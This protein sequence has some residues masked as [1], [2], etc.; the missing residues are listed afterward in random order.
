MRGTA[1][2][3]AFQQRIPDKAYYA[4][5]GLPNNAVFTLAKI[6]W[7][8]QHDPDR[9]RKTARFVLL[10]DYLLNQLG[11]DGFVCDWSNASLTGMLDIER[12]CWSPASLEMTGIC[13]CGRTLGRR[14]RAADGA[15]TS[16]V[17][18]VSFL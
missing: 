8:K 16:C 6:L 10:Q 17:W 18:G 5:T 4:I 9:F 2:I 12:L 3:K 13:W 11:C 7:I 15:L 14:S 1:C